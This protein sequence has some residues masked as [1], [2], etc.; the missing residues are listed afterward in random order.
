MA[1]VLNKLKHI[2]LDIFDDEEELYIIHTFENKV[3]KACQ[4]IRPYWLIQ[5]NKITDMICG[6]YHSVCEAFDNNYLYEN[7]YQAY[8]EKAY[9]GEYFAKYIAEFIAAIPAKNQ[10][11][12]CKKI[13]AVRLDAAYAVFENLESELQQ[14]MPNGIWQKYFH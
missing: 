4:K 8:E 13:A 11:Y 3:F 7:D 9:E 1:Y 6:F 2:F 5:P 10:A 14:L 12:A